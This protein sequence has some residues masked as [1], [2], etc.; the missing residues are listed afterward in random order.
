MPIVAVVVLT[1]AFWVLYWFVQMGGV[2]HFREKAARRKEEARK[3]QA[4]E[5]DR[6][7]CLRAVKD[8]RDAATILM[9][10]IARGGDPTPQQ[11][12]AVEQ[13]LRTAFGFEAERVER[14]TQ[15]RFVANSAQ[16]FDEAAKIFSDLFKERLTR[17]ERVELVD[18]VREIARL[19]GPSPAQTAA[20]EALHRRIGLAPAQ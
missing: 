12:A 14:M 16:N 5:L 8:P 9:L 4:R 3:A 7:A 11:I 17:D 19:D 13:T 15:A 6:T 1:A 20:I 18:M 10:L 2:E